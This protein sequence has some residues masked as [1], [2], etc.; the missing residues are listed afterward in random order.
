MNELLLH[1]AGLGALPG[2]LST[3]GPSTASSKSPTPGG[4][5]QRESSSSEGEGEEK[6]GWATV[7][8]IPENSGDES[9]DEEFTIKV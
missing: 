3:A 8:T 1:E 7:P 9:S 5:L 6:G 4:E 2:G